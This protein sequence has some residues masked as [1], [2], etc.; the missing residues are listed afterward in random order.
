MTARDTRR[1]TRPSKRRAITLG[2]SALVVAIGAVACDANPRTVDANARTTSSAAATSSSAAD[3]TVA[4]GDTATTDG[5]TT[6]AQAATA[7]A[8]TGSTTTTAKPGTTTTAKP[9]TTTSAAKPTTTTP[10]PTSAPT[11]AAAPPP[12]SGNLSAVAG[13]IIAIDPG[14][15]G[16]NWAHS[17]EL[18]RMIWIGTQYRQCDTAGAAVPGGITETAFNL[19]VG[20]RLRSILVANGAT[21]VMS[22][23]DNSG[24]GPC[25][26][27][28]AFFGNN[29]HANVA[30][31]IHADGGPV[32]GRGFMVNAP[33]N[34][35]GYTDDIYAASHR[36]GLDIVRAFPS[37]GMPIA[38][39]YCCGGM[40]ERT[41]FG[42]LNL[43]N[44]PKVLF[45]AGNT[46]NPT[47]GA[48]LGDP[49]WRQRA[50]QALAVALANYLAGN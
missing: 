30:I 25:I 44:V 18:S 35:P 48:L 11:T 12:P 22:R 19:D 46:Q 3:A 8:T 26:D 34:I 9:G 41:D 43:S 45:E 5:R 23:T 1:P 21:V 40:I 39:Y 42:G 16:M 24:W 7:A 47:D 32:S 49:N 17:A 13:K 37:T 6:V 15:N 4:S 50:A 33:G 20:L 10:K 2:I 38:S 27:Q 36:L 31:S 29:A 14:H 28:R